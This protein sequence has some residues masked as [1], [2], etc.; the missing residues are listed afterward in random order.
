MDLTKNFL[1]QDLHNVIA[2]TFCISTLNRIMKEELTA[3][4]L[5]GARMAAEDIVKSL[6]ELERLQDKRNKHFDGMLRLAKD[7]GFQ[8]IRK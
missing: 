3:G 7:L 2:E 6:K 1:Q 4:N 8:I 5:T